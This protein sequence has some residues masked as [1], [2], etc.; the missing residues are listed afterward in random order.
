[1]LTIQAAPGYFLVERR[2]IIN[3]RT[4]EFKSNDGVKLFGR[5]WLTTRKKPKNVINL[6]HGLGEHLHRYAHVAKAFNAAGYHLVAFDLR[7][8]GLSEGKRGHAPGFIQ[9]FD[10]IQTFLQESER[11]FGL[12]EAPFLYGHS[13]GGS[14]VINY[15]LQRDPHLSGVIATA[16]ALSLVSEPSKI[17]LLLA[18]G[19]AKLLPALTISNDLE[20]N[21]LSHDQAIV[22]A[23]QDDALV[24]DKI[25]FKLALDLYEWGKT[26][27]DN[28][29]NWKIPLL[30]MHG[31][32]DQ[33]TAHQSSKA[34]SQRS[35]SKVELVLWESFYHE[36]HNDL[37][38]EKV[39]NKM[40]DWCDLI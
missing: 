15:C 1:M 13:L 37:G 14:L 40:I 11:K 7:G 10:D 5:A 22:K 21:F 33:I 31:T 3:H 20:T 26:A 38:K 23:Y 28:A 9:L 18:K 27:L 6:V 34:F 4:F 32:A 8:H 19:L 39:I 17:K 24:H 35:N 29:Q 2:T 36:V 12:E 16:P 30:L 25:S